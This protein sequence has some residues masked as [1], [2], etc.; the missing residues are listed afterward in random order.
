MTYP[1]P[2]TTAA[3]QRVQADYPHGGHFASATADGWT[4]VWMPDQGGQ[5]A[6]IALLP[7][8]ASGSGSAS[9]PDLPAAAVAALISRLGSAGSGSGDT[10]VALPRVSLSSA[11][12]MKN[13]LSRL[14]MGVAFGPKAGQVGDDRDR[15]AA[16]LADAPGHPVR[17]CLKAGG[18]RH[19][20]VLGCQHGHQPGADAPEAP[21]TTATRPVKYSHHGSLQ[22]STAQ[23]PGSPGTSAG[24]CRR[25]LKP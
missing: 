17:F 24:P 2:F 8:P 3:G 20:G 6:M 14:G 1:A 4:A 11:A 18:Q 25:R 19:L 5:L 15:C 7:A 23:R 9:C 16:L 21:V 13:L 22:V 10:G 12:N